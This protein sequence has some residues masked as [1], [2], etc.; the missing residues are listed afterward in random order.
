M[1][2]KLRFTVSAIA[3]NK[4]NKPDVGPGS[5]MTVK[6]ISSSNGEDKK[7]D[8]VMDK[9]QDGVWLRVNSEGLIRNPILFTRERAQTGSKSNKNIFTAGGQGEG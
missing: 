3:L 5:E 1:Q 2:V 7:D 8:E 9:S 6:A 4:I